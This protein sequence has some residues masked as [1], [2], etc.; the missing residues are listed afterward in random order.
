MGVLPDQ[1][2][3]REPVEQVDHRLLLGARENGVRG[4]L[5]R[6]PRVARPGAHQLRLG[7]GKAI[8]RDRPGLGPGAPARGAARVDQVPGPDF[9]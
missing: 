5:R 1:A 7:L 4:W 9:P 3:A 2:L 8:A 6:R